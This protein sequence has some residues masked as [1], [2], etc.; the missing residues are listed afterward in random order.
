MVPVVT[1]NIRRINSTLSEIT[2][3]NLDVTVDVHINEEFSS[4]SDDINTTVAA[5]KESIAEAERRIDQELEFARI[6]QHSALPSVFPPLSQ[7]AGF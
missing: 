2:G 5:L 7:P 3:G 6:I 4:L 1:E